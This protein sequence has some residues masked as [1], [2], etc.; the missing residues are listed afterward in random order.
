MGSY[1]FSAPNF[2]RGNGCFFG[3]R[4]S[5]GSDH[6]F[7]LDLPISAAITPITS[8]H[9]HRHSSQPHHHHHEKR[10]YQPCPAQIHNLRLLRG[11]R[12]RLHQRLHCVTTTM[13]AWLLTSSKHPKPTR[14]L[15]SVVAR[16]YFNHPPSVDHPEPIRPPLYAKWRF[17]L[18]P[19]LCIIPPT[20][21]PS[22]YL[23]NNI[24]GRATLPDKTMASQVLMF[25]QL[26]HTNCRRGLRLSR[27]YDGTVAQMTVLLMPVSSFSVIPWLQSWI[28]KESR[29]IIFRISQGVDMPLLWIQRLCCHRMTDNEKRSAIDTLINERGLPPIP[30]EYWV[31]SVDK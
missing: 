16:L 9:S 24:A 8:T 27:R 15:L 25:W 13:L 23:H 2:N 14:L 20:F 22:R 10:S 12:P 17:L 26:L 29:Q 31:A 5:S 7:F 30:H 6:F 19:Y 1:D 3:E 11:C 28:G 18:H 21:V 4:T